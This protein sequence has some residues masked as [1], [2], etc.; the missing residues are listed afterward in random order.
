MIAKS[1]PGQDEGRLTS[2]PGASSHN[3]TNASR[4]INT[5]LFGYLPAQ[6]SRHPN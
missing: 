3:Q 5:S 6:A 1:F 4:G 2:R